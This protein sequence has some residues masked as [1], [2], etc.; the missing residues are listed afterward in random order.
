[1]NVTVT[2]KVSAADLESLRR[3]ADADDETA[4][5]NNAADNLEDDEFGFFDRGDRLAAL[6]T[7]FAQL[8]RFV[9]CL[10]FLVAD[11]DSPKI[12]VTQKMGFHNP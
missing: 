8:L 11:H 10:F 9:C 1:M 3:R 2:V 4:T 6:A 7:D 5:E 12:V